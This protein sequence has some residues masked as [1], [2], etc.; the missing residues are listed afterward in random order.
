[1]TGLAATDALDDLLSR[2]D[3]EPAVEVDV[4]ALDA[5]ID[6]LDQ[7]RELVARL[8]QLRTHLASGVVDFETRVGLGYDVRELVESLDAYSAGFV[9]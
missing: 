6:A 2:D 7:A 9:L 1:M 8:E 5:A 4:T 3:F